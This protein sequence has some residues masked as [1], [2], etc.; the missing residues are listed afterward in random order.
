MNAIPNQ[1]Y[2]IPAGPLNSVTSLIHFLSKP[3]HELS[4]LYS[5]GAAVAPVFDLS[6]V[7]PR[8][9]S[10]AALTAFLAIAERLSRYIGRPVP[11][12]TEWNPAVL[13]FWH[14]IDFLS[15]AREN[16]ILDLPHDVIGGYSIGATNPNTMIVRYESDP[17]DPQ[18]DYSNG[19]E[20]RKWKDR[21]RSLY[22]NRLS[23][24][25]EHIFNP[26]RSRV[27]I[28]P[29]I[30]NLVTANA[31]EFTLNALMHGRASAF[32][33]I[34]RSPRAVTVSVCD[35]GQGFPKSLSRHPSYGPA[36]LRKPP[37][38]LQGL[39]LGSLM[40]KKE[41]GLRRAIT[42][43]TQSPDIEQGWMTMSSYTAELQWRRLLWS[44][45]LDGFDDSITDPACLDVPSLLGQP[46][47]GG[48][49]QAAREEGLYRVWNPGL[50]GTRIAFELRL[51]HEAYR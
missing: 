44:R 14:D 26:E 41:M 32:V 1:T 3:L 22:E 45:A 15:V 5:K 13:G 4:L 43:I 18:P 34:Q 37:S 2:L 23:F 17:D 28:G 6:T 46:T 9:Q 40:N 39:L 36:V 30:K 48:A 19:S 33:G 50:R 10:M 27:R 11:I 12:K 21:N 7:E 8:H 24:I 25:C 49:T 20:L 35:C 51:R 42:G 38:H 31:A 16:E 47:T 29:H